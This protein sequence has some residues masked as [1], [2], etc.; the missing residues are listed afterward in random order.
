MGVLNS[1]NS[2]VYSSISFSD[3]KYKIDNQNEFDD[4]LMK[5]SELHKYRPN[6]NLSQNNPL[7]EVNE[8][9]G[10]VSI[11]LQS[12]D[13]I[14]D[15]DVDFNLPEKSD[16]KFYSEKVQNPQNKQGRFYAFKVFRI[17]KAE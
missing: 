5:S 7:S 11:Y 2:S 12:D 9:E 15:F 17:N 3:T 6:S 14:K 10:T 13:D 16:Q 4:K 8:N 1:S